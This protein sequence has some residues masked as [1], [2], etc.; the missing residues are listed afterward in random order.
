METSEKIPT[1]LEQSGWWLSSIQT[2]KRDPIKPS[3]AAQFKSHL[4]TLLPK[5]GAVPLNEVNNK[6]LR[7]LVPKLAGSPKTIQ[8]LLGT[9]KSVVASAQDDDGQSIYKIKWNN[10]FIDCPDV[11]RQKT[12]MFTSEQ[13]ADIISKGNSEAI[14]Y[15]L[16]AGSGLRIG[17]LLAL[18][19]R[20]FSGRTLK[21]EQSLWGNIV[22]T[23][24]TQNGFREVDL[25][26][27]LADQLKDY[28]QS[29]ATGFIFEEPHNY[30]GAL[31]KLHGILESLQIPQ[32]G[33]HAF[34]RFRKTHLGKTHVPRDLIK[35]WLGHGDEDVTDKYD[36]IENDLE[37]RLAEAERAG[38]GF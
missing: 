9:V 28:L 33:F 22:Q 4:N 2:R 12:P 13:I 25:P 10:S 34:R 1:F 6:T 26:V 36:K 37:F 21:I 15:K 24:K 18:E 14:L 35:F 29:H 3:S 31:I 23:P 20:H 32:T 16:A 17:E 30:S 8:C 7:E 38:L 19:P 5:I 27:S 11:G